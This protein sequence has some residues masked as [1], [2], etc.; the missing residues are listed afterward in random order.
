MRVEFKEQHAKVKINAE[1]D[2]LHK[3]SKCPNRRTPVP[4]VEFDRI[5]DARQDKYQQ[6]DSV[7]LVVSIQSV[8]VIAISDL[9]QDDHHR[10]KNND[11]MTS[12]KRK[13]MGAR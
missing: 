5:G 7:S 4:R 6:Q 9:R 10:Q 8:A 3:V 12:E 11:N 1:V 2:D 13:R